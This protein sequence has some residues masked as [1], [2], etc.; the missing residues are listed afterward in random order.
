MKAITRRFN[1]F[2][3]IMALAMLCG[4]QTEKEKKGKETSALRVHIEADLNN[5][6]ITQSVSVVRDDPMSITIEKQA[7]LTEANLIQSKVIDSQGSFAVQIQ[8]DESSGLVLEQYSAASEGRRFVIF[9]QW[10]E[11]LANSR[12]IAAPLISHRITGGALTFTP[13]MSREEADRLV[14]GLNNVSKKIIKGQ[15]K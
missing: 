6:R 8:F 11:K 4:C 12:W 10:G 3:A 5:P 13:D 7:I 9:A 15:L 14:L 2:L 1:L